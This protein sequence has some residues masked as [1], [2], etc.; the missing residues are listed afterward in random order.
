MKTWKRVSITAIFVLALAIGAGG[1]ARAQSGSLASLA[2]NWAGEGGATFALCFT[3]SF[4]ALDDCSDPTAVPVY[5]TQTEVFQGTIAKNG[6]ACYTVTFTNS[7]E[8]PNP[9]TPANTSS[10]IL[11][12]TTTSYNSSTQMVKGTTTAYNLE[13]GVSC[14]GSVL[15]N[16]AN[17]APADNVTTTS[18]VSQSGARID[19]VVNTAVASPIP[20]LGD[21]VGRSVQFKQ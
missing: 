16:T 8:F 15:V 11:V 21:Y 13:P 19:T 6:S 9:A 4:T 7:P 18:V 14:N 10:Q 3:S 12:V 1:A 2:G 17:E 20:F 5:F